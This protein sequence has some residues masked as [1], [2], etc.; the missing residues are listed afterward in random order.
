MRRDFEKSNFQGRKYRDFAQF[1]QGLKS[2][3]TGQLL[4][5]VPPIGR[6]QNAN[7]N[8]FHHLGF[9]SSIRALPET[10][11]ISLYADFNQLELNNWI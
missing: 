7:L 4:S 9:S 6:S 1:H 10:M 11:K 8:N 3:S 5:L 2:T